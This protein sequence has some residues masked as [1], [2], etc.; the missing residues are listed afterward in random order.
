MWLVELYP[1]KSSLMTSEKTQQNE[2][3]HLIANQFPRLIKSLVT[4]AKKKICKQNKKEKN[5]RHLRKEK[6]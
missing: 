1:D 4:Y 6:Q 3:L 5:E 2:I